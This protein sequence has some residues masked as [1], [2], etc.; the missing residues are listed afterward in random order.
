MFSILILILFSLQLHT[1]HCNECYCIPTIISHF[2]TLALYSCTSIYT[3]Y[4]CNQ[5]LVYIW[6]SQIY[7]LWPVFVHVL[8]FSV[9]QPMWCVWC[10]SNCA[11]TH[12]A[13]M[14]FYILNNISQSTV[15]AVRTVLTLFCCLFVKLLL[16]QHLSYFFTF[17]R[18]ILYFSGAVIFN[19]PYLSVMLA[20]YY[21]PLKC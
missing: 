17:L 20:T 3:T 16:P 12:R 1:T 10:G 14:Y 4:I 18:Y 6:L 15:T 7:L 19:A 8:I 5:L 13:H 9:Y 11:V 2:W 21:L